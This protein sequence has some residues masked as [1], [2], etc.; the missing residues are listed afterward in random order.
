M[1]GMSTKAMIDTGATHNFVSEEEARR[2]KLQTSKEAGWLKA[3]N[4]AAKPSQGV[5]RGVIMK[6]RPWEGKVDFTVAPM[7]DFKIVIGMDFLRQ[8]KA[9]HVPFLRSMAILEEEAP[10]M[11]P[12]ITEGKAKTPMSSAMQLKKGLK[13]NEVTYLAAFKEDSIDPM[14]YPMAME[15][16]KVLDEFKDV[17]PPE[18]PS[19][20]Q[21]FIFHKFK[22]FTSDYE[23]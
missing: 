7:D 20:S 17:M 22:N 8:V 6:I 9:V 23:I 5:A 11:V 2:L 12:T 15:V 3:V 18:L 14:G 16:K 13:K 4:S 1:N 19:F 21:L 10:C